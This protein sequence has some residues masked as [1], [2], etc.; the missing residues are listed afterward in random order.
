MNRSVLL[1][2]VL[3]LVAGGVVAFSLS[4]YAPWHKPDGPSKH[5]D[6]NAQTKDRPGLPGLPPFPGGDTGAE[7]PRA[8]RWKVAH[9]NDR[10]VILIDTATGD[11]FRAAYSELGQ[12]AKA[13]AESSTP[14]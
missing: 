14:P 13:P 5:N 7:Q 8:G 9:S 11:L 10:E 12:K 6:P 4:P 2:A 3:V 1:L